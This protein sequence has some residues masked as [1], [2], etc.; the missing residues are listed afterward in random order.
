MTTH[1]DTAK[2]ARTLL[3]RAL[4][5]LLVVVAVVTVI[6]ETT[7]WRWLTALGR[8]L[9]RFAF[10]ARLE[11]LVERLSPAAVVAV[12]VLPFVPI[13]PLLKI[14]EFWLIRHHHFVW[15]A[16][17]IVGTKVVG[18]AF[19]TRVFAVARPK[20]LQV[21][22]FA[23]AYWGMVRLLDIGH[24]TLEALPGWTAARA[25]ARRV[26]DTGRRVVAGLDG[27]MRRVRDS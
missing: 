3:T 10:F 5:P 25:L 24:R 22:W 23:R 14:G 6:L 21:S 19:S 12:F 16:I 11:R 9:G 8:V 1:P 13:I 4:T 27:A 20:M 7:V 2:P 26:H 15:A 18:A 17:V